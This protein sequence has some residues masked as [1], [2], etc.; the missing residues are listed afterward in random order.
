[1][2]RASATTNS[3]GSSKLRFA[4]DTCY[5]TLLIVTIYNE[6]LLVQD[7]E[8]LCKQIMIFIYQLFLR[9]KC[10]AIVTG[11]ERDIGVLV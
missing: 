4:L 6:W 3:N 1:M 9:C 8:T 7:G 2:A 5:K 11:P 10:F